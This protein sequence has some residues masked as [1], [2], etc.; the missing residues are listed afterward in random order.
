[1]SA[2]GF[3]KAQPRTKE[4]RSREQKSLFSG[5]G[6]GESLSQTI[7]DGGTERNG[8][9]SRWSGSLAAPKWSGVETV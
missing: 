8:R 1:M 4:K 5:R 3:A 9:A 6:G 2:A 7:R